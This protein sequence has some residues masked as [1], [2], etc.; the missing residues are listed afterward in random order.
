MAKTGA[1]IQGS[2]KSWASLSA[3]FQH[4]GGTFETADLASLEWNDALEPGEVRGEGAAKR[5]RTRGQYS[6]GGK[7]SMPLDAAK[8]FEAALAAAADDGVSVGLS[9]FDIHADWEEPSTE[10][11]SVDV[12]GCRIKSRNHLGRDVD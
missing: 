2:Y 10:L 7:V 1:L 5:G 9:V 12:I 11:Q 4:G 3:S 8:A 6:A